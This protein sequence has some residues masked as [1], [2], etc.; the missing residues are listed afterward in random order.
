MALSPRL[1]PADVVEH[2]HR[3]LAEI[4]KA[5]AA[6][7]RPAGSVTLVAVS[8][9]FDTEAIGP[10]LGA[11]QRIFGENRVQEA[12]A[13][14]PSL[15][16]VYPSAELH[17][18]GPLQ[19]NKARDAVRLFDVIETLD[20]PK[21]AHA[22]REA[23]DREGCAPRLLVEINT[24]GEAQKL[25]VAPDAADELIALARDELKLSV[26]GVMGIPPFGQDAAPHFAVLARIAARNGL[27]VLSMGMSADFGVAIAAGATHVRLGTAIFGERTGH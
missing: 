2:Y 13:K 21:L 9:T 15:K 16:T 5:E 17:L 24:G 26:E 25:G 23:C 4:R 3:A 20:R 6:A 7:G 19:T 11:G 12:R 10:V 18:I 8:K 22:L 14:W 27:K 1:S